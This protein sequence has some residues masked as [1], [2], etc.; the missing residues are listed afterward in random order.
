METEISE[1][2]A[3]HRLGQIAHYIGVIPA[4]MDTHREQVK[5]NT[6]ANTEIVNKILQ[7]SEQEVSE[8]KNSSF[9]SYTIVNDEL[10]NSYN[11]FEN[12]VIA[13]Y[14]YLKSDYND[15]KDLQVKRKS[16]DGNTSFKKSFTSNK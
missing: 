8:I 2:K 4:S 9:F 1:A 7:T 12:A 5:N 10:Q 11:T 15:I 3:I 6:K 13:L 16:E 14:P